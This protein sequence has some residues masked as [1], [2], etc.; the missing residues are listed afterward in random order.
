MPIGQ[1]GRL[2]A[3]S[4]SCSRRIVFPGT[5]R[6]EASTPCSANTRF[7]KSMPIVVILPMTFPALS[8]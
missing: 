2:A 6:P 8:D 5:T 1:G 4:T 3:A 7:A